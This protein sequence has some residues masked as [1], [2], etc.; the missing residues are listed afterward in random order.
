M[1]PHPR[2]LATTTEKECELHGE[3]TAGAVLLPN[4]GVAVAMDFDPS[5]CLYYR[6]TY[7]MY[8][9]FDMRGNPLLLK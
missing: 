6:V 8:R 4:V 1:S 5:S 9:Q 3:W 2:T 7:I